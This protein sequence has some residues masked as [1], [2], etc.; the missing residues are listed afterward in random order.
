MKFAQFK[1]FNNTTRVEFRFQEGSALLRPIRYPT[2]RHP[3]W[4]PANIAAVSWM[5]W[6]YFETFSAIIRKIISI[7]IL[8]VI[9]HQKWILT[10]SHLFDKGISIPVL[11][12]YILGWIYTNTKKYVCNVSNYILIHHIIMYCSDVIYL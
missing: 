4:G 2:F 5:R 10:I 1:N 8:L 12:T 6:C 9:N 11:S 7:L 3:R